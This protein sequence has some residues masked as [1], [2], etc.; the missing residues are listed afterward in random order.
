MWVDAMWNRVSTLKKVMQTINYASTGSGM[1][2]SPSYLDHRNR[3]IPVDICITYREFT[4]QPS[5]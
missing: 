5:L 1:L 4:W 3:E 2:V